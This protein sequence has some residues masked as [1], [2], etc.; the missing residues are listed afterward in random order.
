MLFPTVAFAV[1]FLVAFVANWLLRPAFAV[2]LVVM[3]GM[4]L[5]F[6]GWTDARLRRSSWWAARW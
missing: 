1:F 6:Y 2:W 4:S 5:L 3:T